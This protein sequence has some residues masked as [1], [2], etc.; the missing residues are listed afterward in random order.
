MIET[1]N[2]LLKYTAKP[3]YNVVHKDNDLVKLF[4]EIKMA[5]Y[6]PFL[7]YQAGTMTEL[8]NKLEDKKHQA[9]NHIHYQ[10]TKLLN[11]QHRVENEELFNKMSQEMLNFN[12]KIF[13]KVHK[14]YY[15]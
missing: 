10:A 15:S 7:K 6:G 4:H 8:N 13:N 11:T 1:A 9:R 2:D 12:K 5:G 3:E 14:S